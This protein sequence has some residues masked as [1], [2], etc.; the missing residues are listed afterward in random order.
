MLSPILARATL[1]IVMGALAS[2]AKA[3]QLDYRLYQQSFDPA[4]P[5]VSNVTLLQSLPGGLS[6]DI[7]TAWSNYINAAVP[8]ILQTVQAADWVKPGYTLYNARL[9]IPAIDSIDVIGPGNT[10]QPVFSPSNPMHVRLVIHCNGARLD[11]DSTTDFTNGANDPS[12]HVTFDLTANIDVGVGPTLA[13][14]TVSDAS[15]TFSDATYTP[16]NASAKLAAAID[17]IRGFFGAQT[18]ANRVA[19][20]F[21]GNTIDLTGYLR[22]VVQQVQ[23]NLTRNL[24]NS[25][26]VAAGVFLDSSGLSFVIAPRV[27]ANAAGIMHGELVVTGTAQLAALGAPAASP[28]GSSCGGFLTVHDWVQVQP[29]YLLSLNP[30]AFSTAPAPTQTLDGQITFS[31]GQVQATQQGWSCSYQVSGLAS[32]F[33]N[34]ISFTAAAGGSASSPNSPVISETLVGCNN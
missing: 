32:G 24:F 31:G 13:M 9:N 15:V 18:T 1:M 25:S 11:A 8:N 19:E 2:G 17:T 6:S 4:H 23:Q 3:T 14:V 27:V 20:L 33:A 10:V 29:P 7:G 34:N 30:L 22:K 21:D 26:T 28:G 5:S 16:D 12:F